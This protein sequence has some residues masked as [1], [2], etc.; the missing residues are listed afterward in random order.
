MPE[1]NK[2]VDTDKTETVTVT[3]QPKPQ[4]T[5]SIS[6]V[7]F[8]FAF[9]IP[10]VGIICSTIGVFQASKRNEKG[11]GLAIAGIIISILNGIFQLV[12]L[13]ILIAAVQNSNITLD[14]FSNASPSYTIKYPKGWVKVVENQDGAQGYIFKDATKDNTGKVY[15]QTEIIYLPPPANG[16][17]KDVL[18]AIRD[19]IKDKYS[20]ATINYES[21]ETFNGL[22][23]LRFIITY[24][25][26]NGKIKAKVTVILNKD[27]SV[28]TIVTQS[29]EENYQKYS[30][31]FDEIHNT[32]QP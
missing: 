9:F 19:S 22:D 11:K 7:G 5:N 1:D 3:E 2:K 21:R 14:S 6:V 31:A 24:N 25:G 12:F 18:N 15:G 29:P 28:Y 23:S 20:G 16:Y 17:S 13:L 30:D 8:I 4:K 27:N 32:F 10:L 26:E